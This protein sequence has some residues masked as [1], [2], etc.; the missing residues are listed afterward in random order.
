MKYTNKDEQGA[1]GMA[2]AYLATL[3]IFEG[4]STYDTGLKCLQEIFTAV[5]FTKLTSVGATRAIASELHTLTLLKELLQ[6]E[7]PGADIDCL[8]RISA[9]INY[10]SHL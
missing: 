7:Q 1:C 9:L 8:G 2:N 10:F 6:L 3:V 5:V 4:K